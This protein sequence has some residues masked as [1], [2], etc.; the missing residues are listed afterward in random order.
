MW[1]GISVLWRQRGEESCLVFG[2]QENFEQ[3]KG[4]LNCRSPSKIVIHL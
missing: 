2:S 3:G 1:I 4:G